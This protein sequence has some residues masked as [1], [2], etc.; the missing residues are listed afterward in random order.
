MT[1]RSH[2]TAH[3]NYGW[4]MFCQTAA[5]HLPIPLS[6]VFSISYTNILGKEDSQS[7]EDALIDAKAVIFVL[8]FILFGLILTF[9][10]FAPLYIAQ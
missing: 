10:G 8:L 7:G 6:F 9:Y 2:V 4:W 1:Y 5:K 3:G